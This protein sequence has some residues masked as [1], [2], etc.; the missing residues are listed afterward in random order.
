M[1]RPVR[2]ACGRRGFTL[3]E[4][5][6]TLALLCFIVVVLGPLL[7]RVSRQSSTVT[8]GQYRTTAAFPYSAC[9][10]ITDTLPGLRRVRVIVAPRDSFLVAPDTVTLYRVNS[11]FTNPFNTP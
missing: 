5:I 2:T 1:M 10:G 3:V 11:S 7:L 9:I 4:T 8:A 6:A